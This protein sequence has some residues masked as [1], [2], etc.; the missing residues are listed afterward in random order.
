MSLSWQLLKTAQMTMP[1]SA[2]VVTVLLVLL[3]MAEVLEALAAPAAP[4]DT[5]SAAIVVGHFFDPLQ[6]QD[7]L[8]CQLLT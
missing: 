1:A 8:R 4:P 3:T 7:R 2:S 5:P 6:Q